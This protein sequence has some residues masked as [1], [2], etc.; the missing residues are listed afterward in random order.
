MKF[1]F[2]HD[3]HIHSFISSCSKDPEQTTENILKYAV[4]NNLK[5]IC[6]T[7]H[8]WDENIEGASEWYKKQGFA[9][10]AEARPLPQA[11]GVRFLFGC[12]NEI[13]KNLT[14]ALSPERYDEFDFI[15]I[16]TTHFHMAIALFDEQKTSAET[17]AQAWIDKFDTVLNMD[18]PFYKIGIAH[19]TC[20]L[21][22]RH[23]FGLNEIL[24]AIPESELNRIFSK[25]SKLG[26][27]IEL[28]YGDMELMLENNNSILRI[29]E[30]AKNCGCKFYIGS[31]SH[32]QEHFEK[33]SDVFNRAIDLLDLKE[34]DKF[35]FSRL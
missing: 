15:V 21:M 12:E 24:D 10:I 26:L 16:P 23:G 27:G 35:D 22:A 20:D 6:L 9:H 29:F 30:T 17:L 13:D 3:L 34:S 14:L 4:K 5:T 33:C 19:L 28:N 32:S 18:L 31:D 2:D 7:D 11:D 1:T 8:F 25:A